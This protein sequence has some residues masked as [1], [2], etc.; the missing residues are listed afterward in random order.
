MTSRTK[1]PPLDRAAIVAASIELVEAHGVGGLTMRRL[2]RRLRVDPTAVY[3]HFRDKDDLLRAV[4][5]HAHG[6]VLGELAGSAAGGGSWRDVVREL[7]LRLR[8]AHLARPELAAL[9]RAAP[10]LHEHEL[11]LTET[12]LRQLGRARLGDD[13]VVSAYHALIELTVGS[14]AIDAPMAS[15][16]ARERASAYRRWRRT[17]AT[18]DEHE[19]GESVRLADRLYPADADA[20]FADALDRLLDGIA[21]RAPRG[22]RTARGVRTL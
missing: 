17:Y 7:C 1:R 11:H 22:P 10:S 12:M 2:G 19:F 6:Q 3:R 9:V 20:R 5:D 18:L 16:P 15:L 8:A 14:A 21:A 4:G 13:E